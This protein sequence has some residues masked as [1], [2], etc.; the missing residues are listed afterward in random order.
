MNANVAAVL[1]VSVLL[2]G[3]V[4]ASVSPQAGTAA[5][6][7]RHAEDSLGGDISVFMQRETAAANGSVDAGMWLAAFERAE[8]QPRKE[9]LVAQRTETLRVRVRQLETRIRTFPAD[10]TNASVAY[11]AQRARLVADRAALRTSVSEAKTAAAG[12]GVN[13]S[14]LDR[15]SRR[16]ERLSVPN[17]PSA[18]TSNTAQAR[19]RPHE[20]AVG[21]LAAS[22]E[23]QQD[24]V[25][26]TDG[27]T[28]A[29]P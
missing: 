21:S 7:S 2:C 27:A 4:G 11:R 8:S 25:R 14:A 26:V 9:A 15:V 10:P 13:T 18:T 29:G 3:V 17:A 23:T 12:E 19:Q 6:D 28:Y 16:I 22:R 1:F 5:D 20:R 24:A